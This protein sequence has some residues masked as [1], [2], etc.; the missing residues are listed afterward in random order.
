MKMRIFGSNPTKIAPHSSK[1]SSLFG[2]RLLGE[3][4]VEI[5]A[6][7][8]RNAHAG[9]NHAKD[10]APESRR[11][12]ARQEPTKTIGDVDECG[13]HPV[14][15]AAQKSRS[16]NGRRSYFHDSPPFDADPRSVSTKGRL[17]ERLRRTDS[18]V[19]WLFRVNPCRSGLGRQCPRRSKADAGP[20][21]SPAPCPLIV[22]VEP[23]TDRLARRALL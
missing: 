9:P 22:Q 23:A 5:L 11:H 20:Y 10:S 2:S 3:G 12:L 6:R 4:D 21:G 7:D 15:A 17:C 19:E 13:F 16:S 8:A 18:G 14:S 1:N